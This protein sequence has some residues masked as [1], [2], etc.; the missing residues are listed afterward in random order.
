MTLLSGWRTQISE[1]A[2]VVKVK[3][4]R[5]GDDSDKPLRVTVD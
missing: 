1:V 5:L 4:A 2:E 3:H